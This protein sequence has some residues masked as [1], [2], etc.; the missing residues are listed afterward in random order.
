M[1]NLTRFRE[2]FFAGGSCQLGSIFGK[3]PGREK[4]VTRFQIL[5]EV[6]PKLSLFLF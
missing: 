4:T 5:D 1:A 3:A 2:N 6:C